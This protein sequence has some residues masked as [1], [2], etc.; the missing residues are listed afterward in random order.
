MKYLVIIPTL[1]AEENI[2]NVYEGIKKHNKGVDVL[3]VNQG[4]DD[5]T[6]YL[7]NN[8]EIPR[9]EFPVRA[10]YYDA[11]SIGLQY[12]DENNYDAVIEFD[13]KERFPVEDI[14]KLFDEFKYKKSDFI[15]G[16]RYLNKRV[17]FRKKLGTSL[18]RFSV[19]ITTGKKISDPSTRFMLY[20]K[21][22]IK[23]FAK[24]D[25]YNDPTPDR[26][27]QL[28]WMGYTY[29]EVQTTL[30]T[31]YQNLDG[32]WVAIAHHLGWVLSILFVRPFR[33]KGKK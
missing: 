5:R 23:A 15:F 12:A 21:K 9:L 24:K 31:K 22:A 6:T 7:L 18:L 25:T 1:N 33:M 11:I 13:D 26:I 28:I 8:N 2:L 30:K 29:S 20:S 14:S 3:F 10:S 32:V 19:W 4:S 17:P 27:V 16:S